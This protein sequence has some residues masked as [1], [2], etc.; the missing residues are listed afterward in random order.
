MDKVQFQRN[1]GDDDDDNN[2]NN[3]NNN[4]NKSLLLKFRSKRLNL[5]KPKTTTQI[6]Q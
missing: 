3:N 4:N 5:L 1:N 2:N 6:S